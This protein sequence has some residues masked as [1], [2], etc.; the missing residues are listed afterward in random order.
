MTSAPLPPP[1]TEPGGVT[2]MLHQPSTPSRRRLIKPT[3]RSY[4]EDTSTRKREGLTTAASTPPG[5][6]GPVISD[7]AQNPSFS[8]SSAAGLGASSALTT[9]V[10]AG[11]AAAGFRERERGPARSNSKEFLGDHQFSLSHGGTLGASKPGRSQHISGPGVME[12]RPLG[13]RAD[14]IL[15]FTRTYCHGHA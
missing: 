15:L 10:L 9:P 11:N 6:G 8:P 13:R 12:A 2:P 5:F 7:R 4:A 1:P 14:V 3:M